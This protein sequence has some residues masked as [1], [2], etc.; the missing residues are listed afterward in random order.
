MKRSA[1]ADDAAEGIL[2]VARVVLLVAAYLAGCAL[3]GRVL[4]G[5]NGAMAGLAI[6]LFVVP[7]LAAVIWALIYNWR[8]R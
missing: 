3:V 4:A 1:V 2:V 7:P 6:G 8:A 5:D